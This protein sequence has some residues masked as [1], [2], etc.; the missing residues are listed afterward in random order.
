MSATLDGGS[1]GKVTQYLRV[2]WLAMGLTFAAIYLPATRA[3]RASW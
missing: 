1:G 3:G 2:D